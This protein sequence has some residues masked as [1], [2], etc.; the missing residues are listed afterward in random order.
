[1][2]DA[3]PAT[4][5]RRKRCTGCGLLQ[6]QCVCALIDPIDNRTPV[7]IL[8][9][10][11]ENDHALNTARWAIAGL[12]QAQ[13]VCQPYFTEQDWCVPGY[14]PVL[15]FPADATNSSGERL[16]AHAADPPVDRF[17]DCPADRSD[18]CPADRPDNDSAASPRARKQAPASLVVIDGTWRQAARILREHP[19][20]RELSRLALPATCASAYR[21]R[22]SPRADGLSTVE[23]VVAALDML[24]APCRHAKVLRPFYQHI[25]NQI[26]LQRHHMGEQA[27]MRNYPH[28]NESAQAD[29]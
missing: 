10:P 14:A 25:D 22:K 28:L 21:L 12:R 24:D 16:T 19:A 5:Q 29:Q 15:L 8:Q 3:T 20:L 6:Q 1:M 23:A 27:F 9:H 18:D 13:L 2:V 17:D 7:R 26:A 11:D 4:G